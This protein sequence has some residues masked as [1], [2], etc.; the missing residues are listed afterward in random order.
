MKTRN[1]NF[2]IAYV[3]LVALPLLG[4]AGALR[5]G[6]TLVAPTSVGGLWRIQTYSV[7]EA[8]LPYRKSL[9]TANASFTIV[10]SGK[11]FTLNFGNSG[12]SSESGVVEGTTIRASMMPAGR[13]AREAGCDQ[14]LLVSLTA[15]LDSKVNPQRLAGVVFV[16]GCPKCTAV[17]FQAVRE[18]QAKASGAD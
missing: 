6:R 5:M 9:A 7:K 2:A 10:Q 8:V 18:D 15:T 13:S 3:I 1:L 16:K 17:D 14:E 12:M 11:N 4:L